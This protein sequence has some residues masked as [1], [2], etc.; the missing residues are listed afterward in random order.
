[1]RITKEVLATTVVARRAWIGA[2]P[3]GYEVHRSDTATLAYAS[4]DRFRSM[5]EA[6]MAGQSRLSDFIPKRSVSAGTTECR[7]W[8]SGQL[9]QEARA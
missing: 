2:A 5:H 1:M 6:Y 3:F 8:Q 9:G 4:P 7:P